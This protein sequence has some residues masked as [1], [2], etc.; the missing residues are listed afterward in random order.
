YASVL[1]MPESPAATANG[2]QPVSRLDLTRRYVPAL[3]RAA[4]ITL[5]LSCLAM[6]VAVTVGMAIAIGRVYG[7]A[8]TRSALI[9]YVEVMRGTPVLLQLFVIYYGLAAVVRLP[10]FLA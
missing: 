5:A 9:L 4:G 1:A 7:N 3:I 10:A 6:A 8:L 2:A